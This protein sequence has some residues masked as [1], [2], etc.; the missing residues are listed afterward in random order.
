MPETS[1]LIECSD[2]PELA[3]VE[4]EVAPKS[5]MKLGI[6]LHLAGLL[7]SDTVSVLN[8]LGVERCRSTIHNRVQ[9]TDLQPAQGHDLDYVAGDEA[10][11]RA[12]D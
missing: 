11:I 6:Q 7:L 3:F 5:M 2:F 4:R 8:G 12:N 1:R 9:K 10:V